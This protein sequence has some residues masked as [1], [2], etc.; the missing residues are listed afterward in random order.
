L[1][2]RWLK[3]LID[4]QV[5]GWDPR[6]NGRWTEQS[7]KEIEGAFDYAAREVIVKDKDIVIWHTIDMTH[8]VTLEHFLV[9]S[10]SGFLKP[11]KLFEFKPASDVPQSTQAMDKCVSKLKGSHVN[12][13]KNNS[14]QEIEPGISRTC[15]QVGVRIWLEKFIFDI[16]ITASNAAGV[17]T[18]S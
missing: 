12:A 13:F 8:T 7:F 15:D 14:D 1:R 16:V 3:Y 4:N 6:A 5:L 2:S 10:V 17:L 9:E 11:T 18:A